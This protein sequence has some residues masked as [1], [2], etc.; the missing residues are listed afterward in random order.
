[1]YKLTRNFENAERALYYGVG[2]YDVPGMAATPKPLDDDINWIGFNYAKGC[3]EPEIHGVHFF[4]DDYQFLRCWNNPD[5][6]ANMLKKFKVVCEPDFSIY[7]DFPLAL[8]VYNHYRNQWLGRYWQD[9]GVNVIPTILWGYSNT[10]DWVFDGAPKHSVVAVTS[11]GMAGSVELRK[12]FVVGYREMMRRLEP[13][14][15]IFHGKIPE[16]CEGNIVQIK[17]FS[18]RL[19]QMDGRKTRE[20]SKKVD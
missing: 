4:V 19:H 2:K 3:D 12:I 16:G 1:M 18:Q 14:Q 17:T 9:K 13:T 20:Q 5:I 7:L 11:Q 8:C 15:I 10:Y 6:Y